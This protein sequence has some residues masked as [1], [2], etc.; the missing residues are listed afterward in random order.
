MARELNNK[1]LFID[2]CG[3]NEVEKIFSNGRHYSTSFII[4]PKVL[5]KPFTKHC[6]KCGGTGWYDS[7]ICLTCDNTGLVPNCNVI[8]ILKK[9]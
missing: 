5:L 8:F 7:L 2:D 1:T 3:N 6:E 4:P 9:D